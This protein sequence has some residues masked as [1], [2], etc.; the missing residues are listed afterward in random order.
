MKIAK[1]KNSLLLFCIALSLG[2]HVGAWGVLQRDSLLMKTLYCG[3]VISLRACNLYQEVQQQEVSQNLVLP[4]DYGNSLEDI[5]C[6][7]ESSELEREILESVEASVVGNLETT[8]SEGH[9]FE[10]GGLGAKGEQ[11]SEK[12]SENASKNVLED[13]LVIPQSDSAPALPGL[14]VETSPEGLQDFLDSPTDIHIEYQTI[15]AEMLCDEDLL[16][17]STIPCTRESIPQESSWGKD[18]WG[19]TQWKELSSAFQENSKGALA[20]FLESQAATGSNAQ[21]P[22]KS[23]Y[24][25]V[26][27]SCG[28][29]FSAR[30]GESPPEDFL[31]DPYYGLAVEFALD[32]WS[33][34]IQCKASC[35]PSSD[36]Q[37]Y[38]FSL[39]LSSNGELDKLS[40]PQ[41][42]WF[43]IDRVTSMERGKGQS[44]QRAVARILKGL[45]PEEHFNIVFLDQQAQFFAQQSVPATKERIE[46]ALDFLAQKE[47][48]SCFATTDAF[49]ALFT[50]IEDNPEQFQRGGNVFFFS[51]GKGRNL[52]QRRRLFLSAIPQ[53]YVKEK[54]PLH[55][56][57]VT[58]GQDNDLASLGLLSYMTGGS[59]IYSDTSSG[60]VRKIS[61]GI[62]RL[63]SPLLDVSQV[64]LHV[65]SPQ[66][67]GEL[68]PLGR[69]YPTFY[70]NH[71]Y[72]LS[73]SIQDPTLCRLEIVGKS[74]GRDVFISKEISL[75]DACWQEQDFAHYFFRKNIYDGYEKFLKTGDPTLWKEIGKQMK[76]SAQKLWIFR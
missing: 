37:T 25:H 9:S 51:D 10:G 11:E 26:T 30:Y 48:P 76:L 23:Y 32:D 56:Y 62:K 43:V 3:P 50:C 39:E 60:F 15:T 7:L 58:F 40:F 57:T 55:F 14:T 70:T 31:T 36:G 54:L 73:G 38:H 53:E 12:T 29:V 42:Y 1:L 64:S 71:K 72:I 34:A 22:E 13:P 18:Q 44:Y 4:P 75:M 61:Q 21:E 28:S 41:A 52:Q 2:L 69:Y 67:P 5:P 45:R 47:R 17:D 6:S 27:L 8:M 65:R 74:Q 59:L 46:E 19:Q 49:S 68:H 35:I 16:E 20:V 63:Q 24:D 33:D 66:T